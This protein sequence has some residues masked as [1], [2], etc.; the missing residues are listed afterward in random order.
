VVP[1]D[2]KYL[3]TGEG[4]PVDTGPHAELDETSVG[5]EEVEAS[6]VDA[7]PP[8]TRISRYVVLDK[9]GEGGMGVVLAAFDPELGRRI[10]LKILLPRRR[11]KGGGRVPAAARLM[12]EA[13]AIARLSH[14]NVV[15]VYDVGRDG[16]SVFVAM[17]FV[18]GQTLTAWID[19][20]PPELQPL[21]EVFAKAGAG[22]AAAHRAGLVHRDFKPDNVL[23]SRDGRV[24]VL[25][26]GL[27]R[28]DG[29]PVSISSSI[30]EDAALAGVPIV[31]DWSDSDVLNSPLTRDDA[32]VGTP[33][34]MAPEQH[35]GLAT[36]GRSD[37]YSFCVALYQALY[38]Q[39]PFPATSLRQIV[40]MKSEGRVASPPRGVTLPQWLDEL[41][42]RGLSP[43]PDDRYASMD[44]VVERL[45][46]TPEVVRRRWLGY[47]VGA[48]GVAGVVAL[49]GRM[50]EP[51]APCQGSE[52]HLAEAYDATRRAEIESSISGV[53]LSYAPQTA[54]GVVDRLDAYA[55]QWTAMHRDACEATK[56]RAEQSDEL[57]DRR[58]ACLA[59]RKTHFAALVDILR[60]ADRAVVERATQ[61]VAALPTVAECGDIERL[62]QQLALPR[63]EA[64]RQVVARIGE[65]LALTAALESAGKY[66]EG[67]QTVRGAL[68]DAETIDYPPVKADVLDRL[69]SLLE[70]TGDYGAAERRLRE[71]LWL[72]IRS[73]HD[74][75]AASAATDLVSVVGDRLARYDEGLLFGDHA[76]AMLDR[77]G[78][79]G[80]ERARLSNNIGNVLYR[81]GKVAAARTRYEESLAIRERISGAEDPSLGVQMTN[82]GNVLIAEGNL[83]GALERFERAHQIIAAALG[84]EHPMVGIAGVGIGNVYAELDRPQEALDAFEAALKLMERGFGSEHPF[85]GVT[86]L[87][88][89]DALSDLDQQDLALEKARRA[90]AVIV[91]A[92]G[93][94]H[95]DHAS[96]L[97]TIGEI[98]RGMEQWPAARGVH[99]RALSL[100]RAAFGP[101][102]E[103]VAQSMLALAR[104]RREAGQPAHAV[105]ELRRAIDLLET[106]DADARLVAAAHFELGQASWEGLDDEEGA[107]VEARRA[108]ELLRA[109][110]VR[111][112]GDRAEI[113]AWLA[114]R[115]PQ[116]E[117]DDGD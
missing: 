60:T 56:V 13:Q 99:E 3:I 63:D 112:A 57:M 92:V 30:D 23:V 77:L 71:A 36:D 96:A 39:E 116:G 20:R 49:V 17:E 12:R 61:A 55:A 24:R 7:Y 107:R 78:L 41:V 62:V 93:P 38:R 25:D 113:D 76:S 91:A 37:Q 103:R 82:L 94:Q 59:D 75:R 108:L 109:V 2:K 21:L 54:A 52:T 117:A 69:G 14:P 31:R 72:A 27:A 106:V 105:E 64:T 100:R 101:N 70:R 16:D 15:N 50:P 28:A 87:N 110:G 42:L 114:A 22:L 47:A 46:R 79:E 9:I 44:E 85:V 40:S 48:V 26:F 68:A 8:G 95:P 11:A 19:S 10:A 84:D 4:P 67:V 45:T 43:R 88:I 6:P 34:Y 97:Y 89:A 102:D 80:L 81:K 18:E 90:E 98:Y 1:P 51:E 53:G 58:M 73:G 5:G 104:I 111:G 33:R 35:A 86:L 32:V 29:N 65:Q 66:A 115:P 74:R 83:D